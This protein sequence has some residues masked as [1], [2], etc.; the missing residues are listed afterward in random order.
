MTNA[1][2]GTATARWPLGLAAL[3]ATL[4]AGVLDL[5]Y[6]IVVSGAHGV[7]AI[8]ICQSIASGLLGKDAFDGGLPVAALG[9]F[10]HFFT[11]AVIVLVYWGL[12]RKWP[13]LLRQPF[14]WGPLYG[15]GVFAVMN[16]VVVPLS[17]IG[18]TFSRPPLLFVGE[19]ASHVF[20]VGMTIAWLL[21]R[22]RD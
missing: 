1:S 4:A 2:D 20:F 10:L 21:S 8:K 18:H 17:A 15:V 14:L 5:G 22:A 7:P 9:V 16:Y 11:M 19:L 6:A 3:F 12:S 13:V